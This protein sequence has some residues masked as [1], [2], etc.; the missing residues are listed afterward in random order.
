MQN[1]EDCRSFFLAKS[2]PGLPWVLPFPLAFNLSN[3][4]RRDV[5][6]LV[7][8]HV[9]PRFFPFPDVAVVPADDEKLFRLFYAVSLLSRV[10]RS[11]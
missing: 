10:R 1:G 7:N 2:L 4:P 11:P 9:F 8:L 6:P 5:D 3:L